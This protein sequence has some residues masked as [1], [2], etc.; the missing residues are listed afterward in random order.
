[1]KSNCT[2]G[3]HKLISTILEGENPLLDRLENKLDEIDEVYN[4]FVY[5]MD[6]QIHELKTLVKKITTESK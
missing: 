5:E 1:M 3:Y 4:S 2:C 6:L